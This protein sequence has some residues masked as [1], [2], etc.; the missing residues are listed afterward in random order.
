MSH[1][2]REQAEH[3]VNAIGLGLVPHVSL[4]LKRGEPFTSSVARQK[5]AVV[6]IEALLEGHELKAPAGK[7]SAAERTVPLPLEE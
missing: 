3:I 1:S 5:E 2:K 6:A 7:G 4:P